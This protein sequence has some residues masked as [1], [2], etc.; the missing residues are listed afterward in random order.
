MTKYSQN[1]P[2]PN[3]VHTKTAAVQI[4]PKYYYQSGQI[5]KKN[6]WKLPNCTEI[7]LFYQ[8][9]CY[10]GLAC[11]DIFKGMFVHKLYFR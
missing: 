11:F 3:F 7:A 10:G 1:G 2:R 9:N 5:S 4:G 8:Y 6:L